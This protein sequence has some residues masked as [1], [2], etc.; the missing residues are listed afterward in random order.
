MLLSP[1]VIYNKAVKTVIRK[2]VLISHAQNRDL[3]VHAFL[4]KVQAIM[5][6]EIM[7]EE[8]VEMVV[9]HPVGL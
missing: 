1:S 4:V 7:V 9:S 3:R 5:F 8:L 6:F 2:C